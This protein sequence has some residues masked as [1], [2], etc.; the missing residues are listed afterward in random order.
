MINH[1][2]GQVS[3]LPLSLYKSLS[4]AGATNSLSRSWER[5]GVRALPYLFP[6]ITFIVSARVSVPLRSVYGD[7]S[8][9]G[10]VGAFSCTNPSA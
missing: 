8:I 4:P 10:T 1:K 3:N 5:A 7:N 9:C 6:A 2:Q